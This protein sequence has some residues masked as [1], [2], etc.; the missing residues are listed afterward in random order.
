MH[1]AVSSGGRGQAEK[2]GSPV[3]V[4]LE[5]GQHPRMIRELL[6]PGAYPHPAADLRLE[7]THISWVL[8]AGPYAYKIKKPLDLG[9]LDFSTLDRRSAACEVEVRLNQRLAPSTYLGVVDVVERGGK[10]HIG[11]PG[12]V[13][14]RAVWMRR[15]PADGM[16]PAL[17]ARN[18][19]PPLLMQRLA[20]DLARFHASAAT[21]PGVDEHGS[22]E[23]IAA[24]W[25]QNFEQVGR[26]VGSVVPRWEIAVAERFVRSTLEAERGLFEE[27]VATGRIRD[28]HGDLHAA[29]ICVVDGEIVPFDCL[30]FSPRYRCADVAAEVA[31]LAMDLD[32]AARA[33]LGWT[34]VSSYVRS[35]SDPAIWRLLNFYK[36]Y[37]AFVRGKVRSLRLIETGRSPG[38]IEAIAAD[39]RAYF[40]LAAAY[41]GG[42]VAPTVTVTA[43]IPG[44]GKTT[45]ARALAARSGAVHLSTD[46]TRKRLARL[47]QPERARSPF[48]DGIYTREATRRTYAE[49]RRQAARWL[50]RG[51]SVVLD[52]T[53]GD[54]RQRA[55]ARQL[56]LRAHAG[57]L[58]VLT[59]C[60]DATRQE[61]IEARV[62]EGAN[63]SDAD[64]EIAQRIADAFVS[65]D[66]LDE[67]E[68]M[69]DASGGNG[70][71]Q[72]I[73]MLARRAGI[74]AGTQ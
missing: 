32:H 16:L 59:T 48:A 26:F 20:R 5:A 70:A 19:A 4:L 25:Q 42:V 9:F 28:G 3:V 47:R 8:L 74:G 29:S 1:S 36:A 38:E 53:F 58:L 34:F 13:V 24:L 37:R 54:P 22:P 64:W 57:F 69:I 11:G 7:E 61:R 60:D 2:G 45:L 71:A 50:R 18:A 73:E 30:E 14:D 10:V 66:E 35:S 67:A 40:D 27:R 49:L 39:A 31:F 56:A 23:T 15:L 41:S 46:V 52:G 6:L 33:D 51:V 63:A 65:P 62:R 21:G 72:V 17:L 12:R 44:S 68:Y 43:G 55:L